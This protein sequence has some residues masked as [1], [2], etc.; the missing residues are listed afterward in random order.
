MN[1]LLP[2]LLAV[3]CCN[4]AIGIVYLW[5]MRYPRVDQ[6]EGAA[7]NRGVRDA[8]EVLRDV[9]IECGL[10]QGESALLEE[11]FGRIKGLYK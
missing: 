11:A 10:G 8:G 1:T 7:Y 2:L 4:L 9:R 6:S 5:R 3:A